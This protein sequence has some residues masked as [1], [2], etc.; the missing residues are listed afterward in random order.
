MDALDQFKMQGCYLVMDNA[1]IH[2]VDEVQELI[3]SR[4]YKIAYLPPY[5][6]FLNL[7]ESFWSK[8]KGNI[9]RDCLSANDNLSA[10]ITESAKKVTQQDSVNWISLSQS[11]F[12]RCLALEPM[13]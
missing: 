6:S 8:I 1:A 10:R 12:D 7:I 13:L 4:G 2:K 5:S 11:F 9:R 3:T